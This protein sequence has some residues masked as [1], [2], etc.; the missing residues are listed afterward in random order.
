MDS[1]NVETTYALASQR[2]A[3]LG[4]D[5]QQAQDR[6]RRIACRKVGEVIGRE[7]GGPCVT[8]VWIPDGMKDVTIDRKSPREILRRSLDEVFAEAIDPRYNLD[9]VEA[10]LFGIGSETYVVGSHEFYFAYSSSPTGGIGAGFTSS[11]SSPPPSFAPPPAS[12]GSSR[13]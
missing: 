6:L 9:A 12:L 1:A 13:T 11:A 2:Y 7:L 3:E 4:V 8:N 10:K 5:T